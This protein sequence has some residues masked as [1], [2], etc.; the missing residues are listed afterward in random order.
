MCPVC[1]ALVKRL[2]SHWHYSR[3]GGERHGELRV[4]S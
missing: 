4:R 3:C 2:S 1:G